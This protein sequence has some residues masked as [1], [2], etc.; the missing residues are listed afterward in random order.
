[1]IQEK[2]AYTAGVDRIFMGGV[3][4]EQSCNGQHV[5]FLLKGLDVKSNEFGARM[6]HYHKSRQSMGR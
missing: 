4:S 5:T 3:G 6:D 1:M 2:L